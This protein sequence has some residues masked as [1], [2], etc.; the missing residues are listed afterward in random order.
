[1]ANQD[2]DNAGVSRRRFLQA[3]AAGLAGG[4]LPH[5]TPEAS[6]TPSRDLRD[7]SHIYH[8]RNGMPA[9]NVAK[10]FEMA[11]GGIENFIGPNDVVVLRPNLQW[12]RNGYTNTD[13]G[14]AMIDLIL[15]RPGGFT[16]EIIVVEDEHR[17]NPHTSSSSGWCTT[18]KASN[19]PYNWFELIQHYVDHAAEYPN[20]IHT[21]PVTGQIN[22]SFQFLQGSNNFTL[23]DPHPILSTYGGANFAGANSVQDGTVD[24][25]MLL[26][27]TYPTRNC[28][29]LR[30]SDLV[31]SS[32]IARVS[33]L[34]N[35][36]LMSYAVFKSMHSGLYV[37]MYRDHPTAWDPDAE[38]F[39]AQPVKLINMSTLNHHGSYAGVTSIVK[40]HFGVV[41][42]TFHSTGWDSATPRTFYY[43][44]GAIGYWMGTIRQPDL[45]MSCAE[46]I[47][48]TSRQESNAFAAKSVVISTDPVALDYYVGKYI[49]FP[50]GGTYGAGGGSA[51]EPTTNDPSLPG[52]YY[53]LTLEFCR[54]PLA[55]H[56]IINGTLNEAEMSINV[57]DNTPGDFDNDGDV[58]LEDYDYYQD[59]HAGPDLPPARP[60]CDMAD[61]DQDTDV[62]LDDFDLFGSAVS[63]PDV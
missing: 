30:R 43:A 31:Y 40:A 39:T 14:K 53:G 21:D 48:R 16:G 23:A 58:D 3:G 36:Y 12:P 24:P 63:G 11:Y 4:F 19:G 5:T 45:H 10:V 37:S 28:L 27:N 9:Q 20:G 55:D 50:A 7:T 34:R 44:G 62:D 38:A 47:G 41:Y 52:G 25:F 26:K 1:M 57:V 49:L 54:D 56:S 42:G 2:N 61:L 18:N 17:S 32:A 22:V 6:A 59:C 51:A 33:P 13:T 60:T 8:A 35:E 29:Y 15:T 46:R